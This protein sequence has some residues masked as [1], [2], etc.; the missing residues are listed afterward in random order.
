MRLRCPPWYR[1]PSN[2]IL[3]DSVGRTYE[4]TRL[5]YKKSR[6]LNYKNRVLR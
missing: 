1:T 3:P 6:A 5:W 2:L 4:G